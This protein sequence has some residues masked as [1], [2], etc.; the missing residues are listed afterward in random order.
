VG[1]TW[2]PAP[3]QPAGLYSGNVTLSVVYF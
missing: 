3:P 2:P 1:A